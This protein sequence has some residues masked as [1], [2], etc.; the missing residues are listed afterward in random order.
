MFKI[1][2]INIDDRIANK[3]ADIAISGLTIRL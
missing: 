1:I 2:I 3:T